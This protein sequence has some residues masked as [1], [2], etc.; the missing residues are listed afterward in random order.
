MFGNARVV[1]TSLGIAD[2]AYGGEASSGLPGR[3]GHNVVGWLIASGEQAFELVERHRAR[4]EESLR[5]S[6]AKV[7]EARELSLGFDAFG[8]DV[9]VECV[10]HADHGA[11]KGVGGEVTAE[12]FDEAAVDLECAEWEVLEVAER[13]V[14]RAEVVDREV[15]TQALEASEGIGGGTEGADERTFG[16]F[17]VKIARD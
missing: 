2:G 14:A 15:D 6:A 3:G 17:E 12:G 8:D 10:D 7:G 9:E 4:E 13:G 5:V 11:D 1:Q 16:D